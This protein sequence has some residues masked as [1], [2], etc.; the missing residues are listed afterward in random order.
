[1][2]KVLHQAYSDHLRHGSAAR[3]SFGPLQSVHFP[4]CIRVQASWPSVLLLWRGKFNPYQLCNAMQRTTSCIFRCAP[5]FPWLSS[6]SEGVMHSKVFATNEC[7]AFETTALHPAAEGYWLNNSFCGLTQATWLR[8][9]GYHLVWNFW[10][11]FSTPLQFLLQLF[12]SKEL[13]TT[14]DLSG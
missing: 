14:F 7:C 3:L 1:M 11:K 6:C 5:P 8:Q 2:F 12:Q 13:N 4:E 10:I 9:A